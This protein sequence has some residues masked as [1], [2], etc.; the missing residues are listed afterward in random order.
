VVLN[1]LRINERVLFSRTHDIANANDDLAAILGPGAV[2][3]GPYAPALTIDND[4]KSFI[5]LFGVARVDSTLFER[6]P[7][8]HLAVDESNWTE[9]VKNYPALE[10]VQPATI[11]WIRDYAVR[12]CNISDIFGNP[13][14]SRYVESRFERAARYSS[15][16]K[17]DSAF[18]E[19]RHFIMAHPDCRSAN[20]LFSELLLRARLYDQ[21]IPVLTRLATRFPNDYHVNLSCG[22]SLQIIGLAKKDRQM[23]A[24]AQSFYEKAVKA[25]PFKSSYARQVYETTRTRFSSPSEQPGQAP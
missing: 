16:Q 14:A 18:F 19:M 12:I 10:N 17:Y 24:L 20:L 13:E 5:H 6:Y 8:T 15:Q 2:I 3:S 23:L 7:V 22:R 9:A 25:N 11:Y 4:V 21:A 1:T